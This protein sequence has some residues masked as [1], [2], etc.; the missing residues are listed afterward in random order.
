VLDF[1]AKARRRNDAKHGTKWN[2]SR[3]Q[4]VNDQMLLNQLKTAQR[5]RVLNKLLNITSDTNSN[6][7]SLRNNTML[8]LR[9][10]PEEKATFH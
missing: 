4:T 7:S 9:Y 1:I 3:K 5:E 6:N 8:A 10:F 2:N